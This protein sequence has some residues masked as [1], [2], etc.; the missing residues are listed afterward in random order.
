M[1]SVTVTG[2]GASL[3]GTAQCG[4]GRVVAGGGYRN[5]GGTVRSGN[6]VVVITDNGPDGMGA[7]RVT[8]DRGSVKDTTSVTV[9]AVC[10]PTG[11]T[12]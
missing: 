6:E 10:L 8:V 1:P 11:P 5:L 2:G 12:S 9:F 4:A 7:W 3:V